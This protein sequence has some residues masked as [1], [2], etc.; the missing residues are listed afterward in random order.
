M[1]SPLICRS[2]VTG[3]LLRH[4]HTTSRTIDISGLS[5]GC[6]LVGIDVDGHRGVRKLIVQ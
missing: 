5:A 4:E 3:K 1:R 6:Y 2:E